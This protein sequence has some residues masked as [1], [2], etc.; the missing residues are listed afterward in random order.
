MWIKSNVDNSPSGLFYK[1][2]GF[3]REG[4]TI[5]AMTLSITTFS[6]M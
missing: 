5:G 2:K 3:N 4:P 6:I 1:T